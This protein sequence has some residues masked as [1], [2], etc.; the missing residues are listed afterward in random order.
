[1]A[2]DSPFSPA[3]TPS[4][5]A[6]ASVFDVQ[7]ISEFAV[8][9]LQKNTLDDL[10]WSMA[11]SVG[12]LL[13][14]DDCVIYLRE[15]GTLAQ[16][17]AYGVKNPRGREIHNPIRIGLGEGIVGAV[18]QSGK[19]ELIPDTER[20]P[21][22]ISDEYSGRSELTV[23]ILFEGEILGV[24]DSESHVIDGYTEQDL[25]RFEALANLCAPRIAQCLTQRSLDKTLRE[26]R[27]H[28]D[29]LQQLVDDR[30][31]ELREREK[32][33]YQGQKMEAI[34]TLAG[35]IAHDFNNILAGI[36]GYTE[37]AMGASDIGNTAKSHLQEVKQATER[38]IDL[39]R[40][41]L[42]FSRGRSLDKTSIDLVWVLDDAMKLLRPILPASIELDADC[43]LTS[44]P[45]FAD[46]TQMHQVLLNLCTNAAAAMDQHVGVITISLA[47]DDDG[48]VLSVRD[49][50]CG[51][52]DG[53][54]QR[55]FDPFF[56]S[57][58]IGE[59]TGL[60]LA[61]VNSIVKDH[62]GRIVVESQLGEGSCFRITLP[63]SG[64]A[65]TEAVGETD[66]PANGSGHILVVDDEEMIRELYQMM[67]EQLGYRVTTASNGS[68]AL[69]VFRDK[70]GHIDLILSDETMPEMTGTQLALEI[71]ALQPGQ[72][73]I[74]CSGYNEVLDEAAAEAAGI[75]RYLNKPVLL[76]ELA[77]T[78][79]D[80]L[81]NS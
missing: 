5:S 36:S 14:L 75:T 53:D 16:V 23:P 56:T 31:R 26:L 9:L 50:G 72:P 33:L 55:I 70:P 41:I 21:R 61:V 18:Y 27:Q 7:L 63:L 76:Q 42:S 65:G 51:I 58:G 34:G 54:L 11:R 1:M 17:A 80:V 24:I 3:T 69:D 49:T 46:L 74:L 44:A 19:S 48:V 12:K 68:Q 59:G 77:D 28:K 10:L 78:M 39:I 64:E 81:G 20:D 45:V 62:G 32:Q 35:G 57:K 47:Q 60:G 43:E 22:Y 4:A 71:A 15:D 38:A 66:P 73:F 13:C 79:D 52:P 2:N 37:L 25:H 8:E 29:Q 30:T 6:D 67:L 40:Q